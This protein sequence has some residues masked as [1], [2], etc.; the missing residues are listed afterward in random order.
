MAQVRTETSGFGDLMRHW[1]ATRKVSQLELALTA[2]V[3]QRH[4]SFL[5]SGRAAPSRDMV[6][7]L[8][9][10]LDVPLRERNRLL[11]AAGFAP[12]FE[13]RALDDPDMA[14]VME[15]LRITL[16][17][18]EPNPAI[19]VDRNWNLLM[20]NDAL[21]RAFSALGDLEAM[22]S[23][24]CPDGERNILKLTFHPDGI[25]QHLTNWQEMAP[26]MLLRIRR[27]AEGQGNPALS[28]LVDE[29]LG[30]PGV[31]RRWRLQ[32]LHRPP[33]PILSLE[34]AIGDERLR[35][36]STI[37]T[38]DTAQDITADELRIESFFPADQA[39]ATLL[40]RLAE[41]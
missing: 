36:F 24:V 14:P 38:F 31:P 26:L 30:Y 4:I 33:P 22:W 25:R 12:V 39:S 21:G 41:Q 16:T 28:A 2:S 20:A 6:Q 3:S 11:I 9:E 1:R 27:E 35:L 40:R 5:E 17:H 15:A 7:Q 8:G 18:H 19:V 23:R 37:A 10:A 29:I 32:D 34:Y 13:A